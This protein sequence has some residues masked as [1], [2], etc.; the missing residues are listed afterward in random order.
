MTSFFSCRRTRLTAMV[1]L[2][3][4]LMN[5]GIGAANA[6][7]VTTGEVRHGLSTHVATSAHEET[8]HAAS[9]SDT[10]LCVGVCVAEQATLVQTTQQFDSPSL[11]GSVPVSFLSGLW[12]DRG[13]S[14]AGLHAV[15]LPN[16]PQ[17][18]VVIRF[19]RLTI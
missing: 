4:W 10:A 7:W 2:F 14:G 11:M 19:L 8:D 13:Q 17:I 15:G 16:G 5:L 6:C 1:V 18:S 9:H 3:V 12:I